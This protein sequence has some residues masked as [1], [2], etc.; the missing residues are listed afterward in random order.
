[1]TSAACIDFLGIGAARSG[2]TTVYEVLKQHPG[3][4]FP[5]RKEL[6]Y[7]SFV[8]QACNNDPVKLA[9]AEKAYRATFDLKQGR[10]AGEISP[11]YL[12]F[13]DV[14]RKI[15]AFSPS[16]KVFC[17]VRD[18]VERALSDFYYAGLHKKYSVNDFMA[19][20][21]REVRSGKIVLHPFSPS[22][23]VFKGLYQL[24]LRSYAQHFSAQNL[25]VLPYD[26][27]HRDHGAFFAALF[28]FLDLPP[29][30][31]TARFAVTKV[32]SA[33]YPQTRDEK[34]ARSVL[35]ELYQFDTA[36]VADLSKTWRER[37]VGA[38]VKAAHVEG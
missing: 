30:V 10:L 8:Q 32:N 1:M 4:F 14:A 12:Y 36:W 28:A 9:A 2:T 23:I 18:P 33:K 22:T 7:F 35:A 25:M 6:H 29:V 13:P 34:Q 17:V 20:G 38:A 26:L 5:E 15:S 37:T 27:L 24:H 31:G 11:S 3:L 19:Q 21:V 16:C